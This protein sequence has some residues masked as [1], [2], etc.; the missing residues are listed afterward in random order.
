[1]PAFSSLAEFKQ[2]VI[3]SLQLEGVRPEAIGDDQPLFKGGLGLDS[4]DALE[5]VVALEQR[6]GWSIRADEIDPTAFTSVSALFQFVQRQTAATG[7]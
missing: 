3:D 1:V 7:S 2:F 4:I 6:G 5:L